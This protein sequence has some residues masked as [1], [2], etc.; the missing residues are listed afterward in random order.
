[1]AADMAIDPAEHK[2]ATLSIWMGA[3]LTDRQKVLIASD[4]R[5]Y[6]HLEGRTETPEFTGHVIWALY[7]DPGLMFASLP[8]STDNHPVRLCEKHELSK[9]R[10][11]LLML[12]WQER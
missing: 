5:K 1:M 8:N 7:N 10:L 11:S 4:P 6:G 3:L 9:E 12:L 2:V